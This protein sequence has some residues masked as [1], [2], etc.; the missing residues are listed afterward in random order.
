VVGANGSIASFA[1]NPHHARKD[2]EYVF[3]VDSRVAA[4]R[5]LAADVEEQVRAIAC[6]TTSLLPGKGCATADA[7]A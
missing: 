6:R 7:D 1:Q 2:E 4:R 3:N 5:M